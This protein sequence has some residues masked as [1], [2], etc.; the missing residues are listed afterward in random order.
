M[1]LLFGHSKFK[2][3]SKLRSPHRPANKSPAVALK[4]LMTQFS[5]SCHDSKSTHSKVSI[6]THKILENIVLVM[7]EY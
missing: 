2:V 1:N 6:S 3:Y 4:D 5:V 7:A